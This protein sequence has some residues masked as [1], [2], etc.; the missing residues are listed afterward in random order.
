[1]TDKDSKNVHVCSFCNKDKSQVE[2]MVAGPNVNICNEC[3][4]LVTEVVADDRAHKST[5]KS[6]KGSIPT[7]MELHSKMDEFVI[8]QEDAKMSLAVAVYNHFKRISHGQNK[9]IEISKSNVLMIGPT[10]SGKTL[11]AETLANMLDVPFAIAD[12]TSL[13]EAGYVGDDV[14][15]VINSL[16]IKCDHDIEKAQRGIIYIDEI[17]K[18]AKKQAGSSVTRDVGGSGVQ[19]ALLKIIEGTD[20]NVPVDS[21]RKHPNGQMVKI[22]TKNILFILGGSFAGIEHIVAERTA[23]K[24]S[25]GFTG[26]VVSTSDKIDAHKAI[27]DVCKE[28]LLKFG[29]IPEFMG[30]SPVLVKLKELDRNQLISV[31]TE[32][33]NAIV[34][35]FQ[36]LMQMDDISLKFD[37]SALEAIVDQSISHKTGA[38][39]LRSIIEEKL[40]ATMYSAPSDKSITEIIVTKGT[41]E[42]G[43]EPLIHRQHQVA[44]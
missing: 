9:D 27:D 41:I 17:D 23:K 38:R 13:T 29:M 37:Q 31:L 16:L 18:L 7:P 43:D 10:G 15:S 24:S 40:K 2:K 21:K 42:S 25:I 4:D 8:G 32:P 22:S 33:K 19:Q 36:A 30:R 44:V 34:K 6:T 11:L 12:A 39:G 14:E 1:M 26:S 35:Q 28:D 5:T 3:N 20:V